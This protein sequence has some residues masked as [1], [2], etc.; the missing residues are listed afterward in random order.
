MLELCRRIGWHVLVICRSL[1]FDVSVEERVCVRE[2]CWV[3]MM[4]VRECK[5]KDK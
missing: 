2:S 4:C 3:E 5:S 1:P